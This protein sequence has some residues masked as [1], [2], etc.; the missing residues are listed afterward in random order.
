MQEENTMASG[1][2]EKWC[3]VSCRE[4]LSSIGNVSRRKKMLKSCSVGVRKDMSQ[5]QLC[6]WSKGFAT[7][8]LFSVR[9]MCFC[10]QWKE[11]Y[12]TVSMLSVRE[13]KC[14]SFS[15]RNKLLSEAYSILKMKILGPISTNQIIYF[16]TEALKII[17]KT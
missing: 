15:G 2:G 7:A 4:K 16:F 13:N 1:G 5:C 6:Q 10:F 17:P 8:F 3:S 11:K 12:A 14:P 9:G